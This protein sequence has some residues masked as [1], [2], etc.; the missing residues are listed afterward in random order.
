MKALPIK[1]YKK[2]SC[3][4]H[5]TIFICR[6]NLNL[7]QVSPSLL[8]STYLGCFLFIH[9]EGK[10]FKW[11]LIW[12]RHILVRNGSTLDTIHFT[13]YLSASS[14]SLYL[15]FQGGQMGC[16]IWRR[17]KGDKA[18]NKYHC[19]RFIYV[20]KQLFV[21]IVSWTSNKQ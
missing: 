20:F 9:A 7:N 17:L 10:T 3:H 16:I 8:I 5:L 19:S 6:R 4:T 1:L 13:V 21:L 14:S 15:A 11:H 2:Y 12:L 18:V